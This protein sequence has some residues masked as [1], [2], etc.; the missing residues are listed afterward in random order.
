[1]VVRGDHAYFVDDPATKQALCNAETKAPHVPPSS[2]V[3]VEGK[4]T[5]LP[6]SQWLDLVDDLEPGQ[7]YR[8]RQEDMSE[9]R[10]AFHQKYIVPKVKLASPNRIASLTVTFYK[11]RKGA[12]IESLPACAEDCRRFCQR[13]SERV[14]GF[15][16]YGEG[17]ETLCQRALEALMKPP[18]RKTLTDAL[19][20]LIFR[21]QEGRCNSCGDPLTQPYH[22]DHK[23]PRASGGSDLEANLQGLCVQCH[24]GK[25]VMECQAS[26]SETNCLKSRF[27]RETYRLF[28][29]SPKSPQLVADLHQQ[30]AAYGAV[31]NVD[32]IRCRFSA[33]MNHK[34]DLPVYSPTDDIK[35]CCG[36]SFVCSLG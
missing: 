12:K 6:E 34:E 24:C 29:M 20:A 21:R 28:H 4:H 8:A 26:I 14:G 30:K 2:I 19:Q 35:P 1:M 32:I 17:M 16:Y 9:L 27:N 23:V 3:A 33:L 18:A 5:K 31:C 7:T 22:I 10:V 15:V 11:S 13:F 36:L 25:S